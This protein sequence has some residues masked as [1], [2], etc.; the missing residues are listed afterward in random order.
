MALL[1]FNAGRML[2]G[3]RI[4]SVV[5]LFTE[6]IALSLDRNEI[7]VTAMVF[8]AKTSKQIEEPTS[9]I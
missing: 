5:V 2:V 8:C 6:H 1:Y 4:N 3:D 7:R 9:L